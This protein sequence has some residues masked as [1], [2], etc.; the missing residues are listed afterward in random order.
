MKKF[1]M[2]KKYIMKNKIKN[3]FKKK[4]KNIE[5]FIFFDNILLNKDY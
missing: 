4:F 1:H 3:F 2:L 5:Y